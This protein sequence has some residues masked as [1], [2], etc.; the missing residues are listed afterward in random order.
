MKEVLDTVVSILMVAFIVFLVVGFYRQKQRQREEN[1]LNE[2]EK[3]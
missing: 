2:E 1:D 3:N